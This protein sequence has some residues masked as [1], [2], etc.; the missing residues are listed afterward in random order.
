MPIP[1]PLSPEE[2]R[3][4][5]ALLEKQVTVPASYPLSLNALR[6]ACNQTSSRDPVVAYD[7]QQVEQV[8]RGLKDRGLVRIVWSDS[9]RRTLKYH[10]V[11]E[12]ELDLGPDERALLTVLLLRG[13]Q[14]PGE[15]RTRTERLHPFADRDAVDACLLRLAARERPLVREVS[16]R[17]GRLDSR[18]THL[19]GPVE[20]DTA[21]TGGPAAAGPDERESV[22]ADGPEARD[23]RVRVSYDALAEAY[24][25]RF[26]EEYAEGAHGPLGLET[27]LLGRVVALAD[28]RPVVEVGSGPGHTTALLRSLGADASGVDLS[29]AMVAEARRR[30]PDGAYEVGDLRRLMRPTTA[31]GWGAVLAWY[32]LIHLAPSEL[33]DAVAALVRPLA[34]GGHLVLALQAAS[35]AGPAVR[36]TDSWLE[37]EVDLALVLHEPARVLAAVAA[38]G[39][40]DVEWY[41]R[42]PLLHHGETTE[43]LY[44]LARRPG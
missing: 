3:V 34:P 30:F 26:A 40:V 29:P 35:A 31:P 32:S 27:W 24:A 11:L 43:R 7:E 19:L 5:G 18:W 9:G 15:L 8:A 10:Q 44:V 42:G 12:E 20:A 39:L 4:L 28:G 37:R 14:A 23:E 33:D 38:A 13:V 16:P 22:L 17:S 25:D 21:A 41:H 36:R 6:T 1:E 2:Q